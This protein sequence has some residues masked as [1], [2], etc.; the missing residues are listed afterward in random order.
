MNLYYDKYL[1]YKK[2]YLNLKGGALSKQPIYSKEKTIYPLYVENNMYTFIDSNNLKGTINCYYGEVCIIYN[3]DNESPYLY[4]F[5][6]IKY[7]L[8]NDNKYYYYDYDLFKQNRFIEYIPIN[9]FNYDSNGNILYIEW[10]NLHYPKLHYPKC[11]YYY[12]LINPLFNYPIIFNNLLLYLHEN[13]VNNFFNKVI[14][15]HSKKCLLDD[16]TDT[17]LNTIK[18]YEDS[19]INILHDKNQLYIYNKYIYIINQIINEINN[20]YNN[21]NNIK[22]LCKGGT[23]MQILLNN[24]EKKNTVNNKSN[25]FNDYII[26]KSDLDLEIIINNDDISSIYTL[27]KI[28]SVILK[29]SIFYNELNNQIFQPLIN[30]IITENKITENKINIYNLYTHTEINSISTIK[31]L[32]IDI[33]TE[34]NKDLLIKLLL[35]I[36]YYIY[37]YCIDNII[38]I[39]TID[40][41]TIEIQPIQLLFL[42]WI[43]NK[44]IKKNNI[45]N[46]IFFELISDSDKRNNILEI[47]KFNKFDTLLFNNILNLLN[48]INEKPNLEYLFNKYVTC[49]NNINLNICP[50]IINSEYISLKNNY[51]IYNSFLFPIHFDM[52]DKIYK[53][54]K[55]GKDNTTIIDDLFKVNFN[56]TIINDTTINN[57]DQYLRTT[58]NTIINLNNLVFNNGL[59]FAINPAYNNHE[60]NGIIDFKLNRNID[61]LYGNINIIQLVYHI[62]D[63]ENKPFYFPFLDINIINSKEKFKN[64]NVENQLYLFNIPSLEYIIK[65][66]VNMICVQHSCLPWNKNKYKKYLYRLCFSI[67]MY[68]NENNNNDNIIIIIQIIKLINKINTFNTTYC[69]DE[70][71][72]K[73][74]IEKFKEYIIKTIQK[75]NINHADE[76]SNFI[77]KICENNSIIMFNISHKFTNF[78]D[79]KKQSGIYYF[80]YYLLSFVI[81]SKLINIITNDK[82]NSYKIISI[83]YDFKFDDYEKL[84]DF[85]ININNKFIEYISLMSS[86]IE[87]LKTSLNKN[88]PDK[89]ISLSELPSFIICP[90]ISVKSNESSLGG[91]LELLNKIMIN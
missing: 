11:L 55:I 12:E 71:T 4:D 13:H 81:I 65:D 76:F 2:K 89:D 23:I 35:H 40:I 26:K 29:N 44:I 3:Y 82:N 8:Y 42:L 15:Q 38:D 90:S 41:I 7:Y 16:N 25:N 83:I 53:E 48:L 5:N 49:F 74:N 1:K 9:T 77:N 47:N 86:F 64:I 14:H 51:L 62:Y 6:K 46:T 78:F 84:Y 72:R 19:F 61:Y 54:F 33:L 52:L 20:F 80:I 68:D 69:N 36:S 58:V 66:F 75:L 22:V 60:N 21:D 28:F 57:R 63:I 34:T 10:D 73:Q 87:D 70:P 67:F 50:Y 43:Y 59:Q 85:N 91:L 45:L 31:S 32:N 37:I 24:Y 17:S 27:I 79:I 30:Y 56:A 18:D 88:I 39:T